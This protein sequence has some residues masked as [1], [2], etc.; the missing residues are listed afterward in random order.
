MAVDAGAAPAGPGPGSIPALGLGSI[1]LIVVSVTLLWLRRKPVEQS[2]PRPVKVEPLPQVQLKEEDD[3]D[4]KKRLAVFFGTQT[5]T[6]EGFA[7]A[8]A[9]EARARYGASVAVDVIDLDDYGADEEAYAQKLPS[10]AY[11][12]FFTATYGD[13]EPTDNAAR[14]MK[15]ITELTGEE[16]G[17]CHELLEKVQ[18]AV[19]GLGNRQYEHFN[20]VAKRLDKTMASLGAKRIAATGF[21]DDDACIEDDFAAW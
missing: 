16:E 3:G 1:L 14:F 20:S 4:K 11:A 10:E 15:W 7:K 17:A 12:L 18:Y 19:F 13:G 5:G 21:G 2:G 8:V 9:E 6:A